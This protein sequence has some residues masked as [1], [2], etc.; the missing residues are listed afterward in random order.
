MINGQ[1]FVY[2]VLQGGMPERERPIEEPGSRVNEIIE[3]PG[4]FSR[5]SDSGIEERERGTSIGRIEPSPI[6]GPHLG[7]GPVVERREI[8]Y[9]NVVPTAPIGHNATKHIVIPLPPK[10]T[11]NN[12][13][14]GNEVVRSDPYVAERQPFVIPSQPGEQEEGTIPPQP[15]YKSPT[16]PNETNII[17]GS[18]S[19][20]QSSVGQNYSQDNTSVSNNDMNSTTVAH[21]GPNLTVHPSQK[22]ILDGS[23][24]YDLNGDPLF[25]YGFS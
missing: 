19:I 6:P 24:S 14:I 1:Q 10:N 5:T 9:P 13:L 21:P 25:S 23:K 17:L 18:P 4:P 12:I 7:P 11:G 20:P 2:S 15:I 22:V 3:G 8:N 16:P